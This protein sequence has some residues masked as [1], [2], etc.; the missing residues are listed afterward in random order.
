MSFIHIGKNS[1]VNG[2]SLTN[3][4][5]FGGDNFVHVE[6][7]ADFSN[8]SAEGNIHLTNEALEILRDM[9]RKGESKQSAIGKLMTMM[10]ATA[11]AHAVAGMI[12]QAWETVTG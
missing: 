3:N 10:G 8:F 2:V 12:G 11:D 5:G 9:K 7:G 6:E 1:K 4:R